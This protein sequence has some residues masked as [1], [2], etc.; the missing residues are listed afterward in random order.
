MTTSPTSKTA[1]PDWLLGV[2]FAATWT[3]AAAMLVGIGILEDAGII[4]FFVWAAA[5][6]A[7]IPFF[8]WA[9]QRWPALWDQTRRLPMRAVMTLMLIFT[10]WFNLTGIRTAAEQ[11]GWFAGMTVNWLTVIPIVT[12]LAVWL[13]TFYGGIRW[14][15]ASD[16]VQWTLELGAVVAMLAL[17]IYEHGG[18]AVRPGLK[19]GSYTD[20]RGWILGLWTVP[21][22]LGNPFLDGTFWHRA[23]YA[24]SMR[25]YWWGFGMFAVY[26]ACVTGIAFMGLTPLATGLLFGVIFFAS[27]STLD[28]C[29][30][31]LQL[32]AG[33]NLGNALGLLAAPGWLLAAPL[34][35]LDLWT[36]GMVWVPFIAGA[37]AL[38][39]VLQR[40][41]A[42]APPPVH[43]LAAR[44]ALPLIESSHIVT[45]ESVASP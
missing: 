4:P 34:G 3:W 29:T 39:Y 20:L 22:L 33:R 16:R 8:G 5:N 37:Q 17:V 40:R 19:W 28:S 25:P 11:T 44:D 41:G 15:V 24:K 1:F 42:I 27:F 6:V 32:T 43:T 12:L 13:A 7:A 9:S 21:M 35:L 23:A 31:A 2:S 45:A 14:S 36:A 10:L 30:A 38:T 26:L 18:I